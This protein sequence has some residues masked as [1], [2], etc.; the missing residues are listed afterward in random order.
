M[1]VAREGRT[2]RP[3]WLW[4]EDHAVLPALQVRGIIV[5]M[6]G[7]LLGPPAQETPKGQGGSQDGMG[8]EPQNPQSVRRR[9]S[10]TA[11]PVGNSGKKKFNSSS[12]PEAL[13]DE[14][15]PARDGTR[16]SLFMPAFSST[17]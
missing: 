13:H 6:G 9:Q 4:R 10:L 14:H 5:E 16:S 15:H 7:T 1:A 11:R 2:R 8:P 3:P 12:S 17:K